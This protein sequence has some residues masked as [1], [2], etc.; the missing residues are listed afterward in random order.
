MSAG[1]GR[2]RT[3]EQLAAEA[4]VDPDDIDD[5]ALAEEMFLSEEDE[6]L[7]DL[8]TDAMFDE[9]PVP[10]DAHM[11][12]FERQ[13]RVRPTAKGPPSHNRLSARPEEMGARFLEGVTQT[14]PT[15]TE[16]ERELLDDIANDKELDIRGGDEEP[17]PEERPARSP[18]SPSGSPPD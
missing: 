3:R 18:S 5:A 12:D 14:D 8:S 2:R 4:G 9:S 17:A 7:R 16:E 15:D 1:D 6:E 13:G 11:A 10:D